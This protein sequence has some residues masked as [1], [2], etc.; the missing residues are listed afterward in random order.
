M[1]LGMA[2]HLRSN[3]GIQEHELVDVTFTKPVTDVNNITA[4]M[5]EFIAD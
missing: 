4:K 1:Y 3:Y 2:R 5:F